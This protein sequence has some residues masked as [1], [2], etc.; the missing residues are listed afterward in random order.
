MLK[1]ITFG[2]YVEGNSC[3]HRLDPRVK[4]LALIALIVFLF[5]V[6]G[7]LG[8]AVFALLFLVTAVISRIPVKMF[9]KNLKAIW[10]ILL[11]TAAINIFYSSGGSVLFE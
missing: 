3:L 10:V 11:F 5:I 6:D 9:L 2:Q 1:D 4:L 7:F 8:I